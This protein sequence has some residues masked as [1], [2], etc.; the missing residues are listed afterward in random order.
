MGYRRKR[1]DPNRPDMTKWFKKAL[2]TY[3]GIGLL[4]AVAIFVASSWEFLTGI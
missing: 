2:L 4:I 3:F 1:L